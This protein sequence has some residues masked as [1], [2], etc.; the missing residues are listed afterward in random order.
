MEP[1]AINSGATALLAATNIQVRNLGWYYLPVILLSSALVL[2]I[3]LVLNNI[4][5]RY[6]T[7]WFQ[8][9]A[10]IPPAPNLGRPAIESVDSSTE[11]QTSTTNSSI[12]RQPDV[13]NAV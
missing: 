10:T 9:A 3:A 8:P 6:P 2:T 11:K 4:Q 13:S 12:S 5:R 1:F 7:F